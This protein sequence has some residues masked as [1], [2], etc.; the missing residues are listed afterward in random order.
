MKNKAIVIS[1]VKQLSVEELP[2]PEI[3]SNEVLYEVHATSLCTVEQRSYLGA[4][5]FGYPLL[6]GHENSGVVVAVG[7][8]VREYKV[9][10]RITATYGYCGKCVSCKAGR[11]PA[12]LNGRTAKKRVYFNG[13]IIGGSLASYL[14]VPAIQCCKLPE[15]ADFEKFALTEPLACC[16][17]SIDKGKVEFGDAVVVIGAGIMGMLHVMLAKMKG[18]F[19]IVSEIDEKRREKALSL[20]A[21]IA[22]NPAV[23]NAVEVVKSHTDGLGADVVVNAI[24]SPKIWPDAMGML[25]P[26]GRLL[27]YSS[28]DYKEEVGVDMD[29]LHSKEYEY[30]GTVSPSME[31]NL[32]ASKMIA[33]NLIDVK[34][35]VDAVYTFDEAEKAFEHA[36]T[37]NTY[38]VIIKMK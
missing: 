26:Y 32:R 16:I 6:G 23:E 1:G 27:A 29:K 10:D 17:H 20:G 33:K 12:C 9:G 14:A 2:M 7:S 34:A 5:A 4:K 24:G 18:A 21:N 8:D 3:S 35:L 31:S 37:P 22:I 36:A 30:I 11:G 25:A 19:V 28:Q 38:R 13:I 15:N